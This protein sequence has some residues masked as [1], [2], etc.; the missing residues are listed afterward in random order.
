MILA[1]LQVIYVNIIK[2]S[3]DPPYFD[4]QQFGPYSIDSNATR[5]TTVETI[6][7]IIPG[8]TFIPIWQK[9]IC[10]LLNYIIHQL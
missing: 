3:P 6:E 4:Q 8:K 1:Q 10:Y 2:G 5:N 9:I 7:A